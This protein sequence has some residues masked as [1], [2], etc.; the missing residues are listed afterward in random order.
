MMQASERRIR[1]A[2]VWF[3]TTAIVFLVSI[4]MFL[5]AVYGIG[6]VTAKGSWQWRY[7]RVMNAG[8]EWLIVV[9][10][11]M[12]LI[13]IPACLIWRQRT[14]AAIVVLPVNQAAICRVFGVDGCGL[15]DASN[16]TGV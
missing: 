11:F 10:W 3:I 4:L 7:W 12:L 16:C 15:N 2:R 14:M 6:G 5:Y 8:W 13:F 9:S 1:L